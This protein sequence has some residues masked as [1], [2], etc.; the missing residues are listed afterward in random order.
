M[1]KS[2]GVYE[3]TKWFLVMIT[4][5]SWDSSPI[6][7]KKIASF[8]E[9]LQCEKARKEITIASGK[10]ICTQYPEPDWQIKEVR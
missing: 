6:A 10:S 9:F 4:L 5:S 3:V 2:K 7:I 1:E 8:D